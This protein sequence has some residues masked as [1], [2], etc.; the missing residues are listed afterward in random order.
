MSSSRRLSTSSSSSGN[1]SPKLFAL[2]ST[3]ALILV[4]D[5]NDNNAPPFD[6]SSDED[7]EDEGAFEPQIEMRRASVPPLPPSVV[8]LYL[9]SPYLKLGA[10]FL[11]HVDLPLKYGLPPLLFFAVLSAFSRQIW[12]MLARYIR[13]VDTEDV[14]LDSFARGRGKERRREVLR[15]IIRGGTGIMRVLLATIYLRG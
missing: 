14:I 3:S 8:F 13:R 1:S 15:I 6:F 11:P 9:L 2:D 7:P 12:Y 4:P 10:M 5:S